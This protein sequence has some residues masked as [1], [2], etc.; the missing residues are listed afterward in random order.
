M[1]MYIIY[2]TYIF[3]HVIIKIMCHHPGYHHNGF[4][5][6]SYIFFFFGKCFF[7]KLRNI[8]PRFAFT[9]TE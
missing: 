6:R 2:N 5:I 1:S 7:S 9:L 4:E 3:F 8:L